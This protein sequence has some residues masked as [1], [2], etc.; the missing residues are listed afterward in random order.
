[1][2]GSTFKRCTCPVV[3]DAKGRRQNCQ[4]KHG[5][6]SYVLD[7]GI[8]PATGK[9]KQFKRGGF[10]TQTAAQDAL[11][12]LLA[13]V[14]QG[15]FVPD[16]SITVGEWLT[17]WVTERETVKKIKAS[18]A[19]GYR[20]HMRLHLVPALGHIKLRDLRPGHVQKLLTD[21]TDGRKAATVLRVHAT[22]RSAL[23]TAVKKG[24]IAQ[25]PATL[26]ELPQSTRPKVRP[27]E[28]A[29]LGTFLDSVAAHP[30]A[31]L[32]ETIAGAGLRR[33][34]ALGLRWSDVDLTGRFLIVRQQIK[35]CHKVRTGQQPVCP[36]CGE[37]HPGVRFDTPKSTGRAENPIE[38]DDVV[39][40]ALLAHKLVQDSERAE[41]GDAYRDHDL[42]FAQPGGDPLNPTDVS[43][44]FRELVDAA[45]LRRI[46]LHDLRH[47]H[48]SL[49]LAA[50][51]DM[52][53]VS[54]RIGHSSQAI[55]VDT[56]AHLLSGVGREAAEKAAA[57]VPRKRRDQSVTKDVA[58][59]ESDGVSDSSAAGQSLT[60]GGARGTRTHNLRIKSPIS[61]IPVQISVGCRVHL[62]PFHP[63]SSPRLYR[64]M[65]RRTNP[66]RAARSHA[67]LI[68]PP[69]R[70]SS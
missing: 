59:A 46:R 14:Q 56:Y 2:K 45:G 7:I 5:S 9:R 1:M 57:L 12:E 49:M 66:S 47:G 63:D 13:K 21:L 55:T 19:E 15:T 50:G 62:I 20:D 27:W 64:R 40:G 22:L 69:T 32:F 51:V 4:K 26:V 58:K 70:T 39:M 23:T 52:S 35:E 18:T 67:A 30:L 37:R 3:K 54:K 16:A 65:P 60:D 44:A 17:Q 48:A 38:L 8:D 68:R 6:W 25:N 28:A 11:N 34:E 61:D 10:R 53:L 29:D 36:V 41:W 31:A 33:G 43:E 24:L 42:V